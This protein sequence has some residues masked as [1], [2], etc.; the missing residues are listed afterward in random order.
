M[1]LKHKRK[2]YYRKFL[3][4]LIEAVDDED[5]MPDNTEE[6]EHKRCY[7]WISKPW[8]GIEPQILSISW[9]K[10][11]LDDESTQEM[12]QEN[13]DNPL[14]LLQQIPG[15]ENVNNGDDIWE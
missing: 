12:L 1:C 8:D 15:F 3:P 10:L 7:Y 4:V 14:P 6:S 9:R 5:C 11:L 13:C 2:K